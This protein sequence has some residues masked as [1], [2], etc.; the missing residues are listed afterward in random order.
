MKTIATT[1][2]A[3]CLVV[4]AL[5]ASA[6]KTTPQPAATKKDAEAL[7]E[8][9][10]YLVNA[11][12]CDDCHT[13][14]KMGE[15]GSI[16]PDM[17]RRLSGHP[18]GMQLP[19]PPKPVGPW[20][21]SVAATNTAW[22]GPWGISYTANLTSDAETGLGSWTKEN[23]VRTVRTGRHLGQ[24]R[25]ILPPMPIFAFRDLTDRDVEAI[26]AFL[27]TVPAIKNRVPTPTP[28]AAK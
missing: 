5:Y 17:S 26:F 13:P 22:A 16:A 27:Q 25:P 7:V 28:P 15:D 1:L 10:A 12:A 19:P 11:M 4:T 23:F 2:L 9:G 3:T 24:G 14:L 20:L 8:R 6:A 18:E 21:T